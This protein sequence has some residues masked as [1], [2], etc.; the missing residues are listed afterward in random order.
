MPTKRTD[1]NDGTAIDKAGLEDH[2]D[3]VDLLVASGFTAPP[4]EPITGFQHP[5]PAERPRE[6]FSMALSTGDRCS[7]SFVRIAP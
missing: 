7:Q 3:I 2:F 1:Q 4:V 5:L 6:R